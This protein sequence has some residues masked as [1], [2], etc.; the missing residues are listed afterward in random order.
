[1]ALP[2]WQPFPCSWC[3]RLKFKLH[4]P[5]DPSKLSPTKPWSLIFTFSLLQNLFYGESSLQQ[6]RAST[7]VVLES[8]G[9]VCSAGMLSCHPPAS[10]REACLG[11]SKALYMWV[12]RSSDG[13]AP[14]CSPFVR[15]KCES[16]FASG[17]G[18]TISIWGS[19]TEK[20]RLPW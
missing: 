10:W 13:S 15:S 7:V 16:G 4:G 9:Q 8:W 3:L 20:S 5:Q 17:R 12:I 2:G 14:C 18:E 1:M 6:T 19:G 11:C